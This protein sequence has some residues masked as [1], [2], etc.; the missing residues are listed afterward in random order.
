MHFLGLEPETCLVVED[1]DAGIEAAIA[2]GMYSAALSPAAETGKAD[3][4]L[5][6]FTDLLNIAALNST[7]GDR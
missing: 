7:E 6:E 1:A 2:A 5:K 3:Y 4:L